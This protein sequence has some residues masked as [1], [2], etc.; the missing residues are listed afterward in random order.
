VN[1]A[2]VSHDDARRRSYLAEVLV[3]LKPV[4]NDPQGLAIRD[5][6]R[7][8]GYAE[9]ETVRAGKYLRVTVDAASPDEAHERVTRMCDQLLSNPVTET[10]EIQLTPL[11]NH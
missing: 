10:Y 1:N 11:A 4:V 8:L 5:G 9:V 2:N 6:L 7:S 3:S